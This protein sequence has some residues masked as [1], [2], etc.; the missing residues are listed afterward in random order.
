MPPSSEIGAFLAFS[1]MFLGSTEPNKL[2][3]SPNFEE[4][5]FLGQILAQNMWENPKKKELFIL[6]RGPL[7]MLH[8]VCV[9]FRLIFIC[10]GVSYYLFCEM[11]DVQDLIF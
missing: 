1:H 9:V 3:I 8:P 2:L 7:F 11:S 10:L 4:K 6:L 5:C